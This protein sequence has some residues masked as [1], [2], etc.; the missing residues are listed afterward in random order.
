MYLSPQ[1]RVRLVVAAI[2][3]ASAAATL[4]VVALTHEDP[5]GS[6]AE[7]PPL[8]LDLGVR[9]DREA[10]DLRRA[11]TLFERG[12]LAAAGRI[13][14]R[15]DSPEARVGFAF[16]S[17]PDTLPRLRALPRGRAVVRL[18]RG[19]AFAAL[20]DEAQ[21]RAELRAAARVEPDTR[22]AIRADD[23]LHP[24]LAPGL[25]MFVA[26]AAF[27]KRLAG[28][29]PPQQFAAV[30]REASESL[31]AALRYGI[32]L[33]QLGR[34]VSARGAFDAALRRAP[35][36]PEALTAAAVARFDKDAPA[37]AF[38]RLGPLTR[39]FPRAQTVHFHLG[40][41]LLWIGDVQ[42]AR[43]QLLQAR[44]LGPQTRLGR[45][46]KRFLDRL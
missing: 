41:L 33:Q 45:E 4:A 24:R 18:H 2:A 27:P 19:I 8:F 31:D 32:A 20:G 39:R 22:Y 21:A 34:P 28:L 37:A 12:D 36:D 38:G 26:E 5:A 1:V 6:A 46:A 40:V 15:H 13:F 9:T 14:A 35:D 43:R 17:W 42:G 30:E 3:A 16:A 7:P 29:A 44:R 10:R 11:A 25:P 23:F